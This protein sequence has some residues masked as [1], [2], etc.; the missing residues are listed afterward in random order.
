MERYFSPPV[1]PMK[2]ESN[3][4]TVTLILNE[5]IDDQFPLITESDFLQDLVPKGGLLSR[6]MSNFKS[7]GGAGAAP[8]QPSTIPWRRSNVKHTN[9]ELYVDLVETYYGMFTTHRAARGSAGTA[10]T[11]YSSNNGPQADGLTTARSQSSSLYTLERQDVH[12]VSPRTK[13]VISRVEGSVVVTSNLSG[14]PTIQIALDTAGH[15]IEFPS[16]HP[17]VDI[18]HWE[19]SPGTIRCIP[20]DGKQLI[21][22][23]TLELEKKQDPL[24]QATITTGL[25]VH[26]DEFEVRVWSKIMREVQNIEGLSVNIVCD[27]A[28]T[29]GIGNNLRVTSGD[30]HLNNNGVGEWTFAGKTPCGWSATLRGS[31]IRAES[32][33]SS[34]NENDHDDAQLSNGTSSD[35]ALFPDYVTLT[36]VAVG[37]IPSGIKVSNLRLVSSRGLGE[38]VKP[39]KGVR[40]VT[41]VG[42]Y[43]VR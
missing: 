29:R 26:G 6:F 1:V 31:L 8:T 23:Y 9:N 37:N 41:N 43:V 14:V 27:A 33:D 30:F 24:V 28:K 40:Y 32:E 13:Q 21:A 20:P 38:G 19:Q 4:D 42:E 22:S 25:G 16:F 11:G 3:I 35:T 7:G 12:G 2:I 17:C 34:D 39:Y 10:G 15:K 5:M 18:G 36:Y